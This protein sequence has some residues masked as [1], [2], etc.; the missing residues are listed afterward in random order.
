MVV[1]ESDSGKV[2]PKSPP[3][4]H[5]EDSLFPAPIR[6]NSVF[7][8]TLDEYQVRSGKSFGSM[9]MDELINSIWNGDENILFSVSSQDE[10][11]NDK[12]MADQTDL[13]RQASFSIPPPLCKKTI[14]EVW[15]E[16]NKNKQQQNSNNDGSN[17]SVQGEQTFGEMTLEDFLVK[18][19]VVQDVF[20]E[21]A[22]GSSK[23]HMLTPT[24]RSGSF[25]NNNTNLETTFG[26]GNMMGLEFSA[27]QNS[28]NNLSSNDLAAYLAQGNKFPGESS[29]T[30]EE[31]KGESAPQPGGQRGRKRTTDGTLEMAVER[32]QRRMIK[33]RES[34]ARSRARKQ[35]YT[36]ELELELNQLKEENTKLKK[37]VAEAERKR[38]EKQAIEGKEATKAQ[39][40]AKQLKKLR[41][42]VSAP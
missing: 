1:S 6:Q 18:A 10:L 23:R 12:H 27:S 5:Q 14:D 30:K 26:I 32:R 15:S 11:N 33:N 19:G 35:A 39:K 36:V 31:E 29:N 17:D 2:K 34:A 25:P 20:V 13:P 4:L 40:I 24:Q 7:S 38:R 8:L 22:S 9:N 3:Q 41:R 42:T 28:G 37:I 21:E 16:I